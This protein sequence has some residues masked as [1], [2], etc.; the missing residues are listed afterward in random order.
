ML[1]SDHERTCFC[2]DEAFEVCVWKRARV[3]AVTAIRVAIGLRRDEHI[4][5]GCRA[6][7]RLPPSLAA[8]GDWLLGWYEQPVA[9]TLVGPFILVVL[10]VLR[11]R[12]RRWFSPS[13]TS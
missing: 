10:D 3:T 7:A 11:H 4:G 12:A 13:D 1:F 2:W 5:R 9:N 6:P 8:I